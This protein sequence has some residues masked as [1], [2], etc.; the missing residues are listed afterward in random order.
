[1]PKA[2]SLT[3]EALEPQRVTAPL[4]ATKPRG[5]KDDAP[6]KTIKPI[7]FRPSEEQAWEIK[8]AASAEHMNITDF[9]LLCFYE[10]M[11]KRKHGNM[12]A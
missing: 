4:A 10:H 2:M 9:M 3:P 1:M 12:K 5:Q 6:K 7:Q 11:E 8:T